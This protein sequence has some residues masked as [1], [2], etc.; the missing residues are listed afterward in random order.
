M[1][2][3]QAESAGQNFQRLFRE[4]SLTGLSDGQLL[5]RYLASRDEFAFEVLVERHAALVLSVCRRSLDDPADCDDA[6]Q[7]T[8]LVLARRGRVVRNQ[9]ALASWLFGVARR[10]CLLANRG[11]A[12]RR[13][14]ERRAAKLRAGRGTS[15]VEPAESGRLVYEEI[16]RLPSS[17]RLPVVLCLMEGRSRSEAAATLCWTES[18]V[19]GRLAR[20]RRLL[21]S[22]LIRRGVAPAA[23]VA[24]LVREGRA[25][26]TVP[27]ALVEGAAHAASG[28]TSAKVIALTEGVIKIML[29]KKLMLSAAVLCGAILV[30]W[31]SA[32]VLSA[33]EEQAPAVAV[34]QAGPDRTAPP[35]FIPLGDPGKS[36][37]HG[38]VIDP[39]GKPVA[40]AQ[41]RMITQGKKVLAESVTDGTGAFRLGPLEPMYRN[42]FELIVDA[43]GLGRVMSLRDAIRSFPGLDG[44]VGNIQLDRGRVFTGQVLDIDG[45]TLP[46]ATIEPSVYRHVMGHTVEDIGPDLT[47]STDA[48]GRFRTPPLPVGRLAL[49]VRAAGR[50]LGRFER[51]IRPGGEEDL[52][53]IRLEKDVPV[54]GVVKDE[55]GRPIDGVT[56]VAGSGRAAT[57]NA[58]GKFTVSGLGPNPLFQMNVRKEGYELLVGRVTVTDAGFRYVTLDIANP[59]GAPRPRPA[60]F[61]KELAVTLK[62]VGWIDGRAV[63]SDT[64]EPVRLEHVALREFVRKPNGEVVLRR[65]VRNEFEQPEPGRFRVAFDAPDEFHLTFSAAGYQDAEAFTPKVTELKTVEGIVARMKKKAEGAAPTIVRQTIAGTVTREGRP[66]KSGWVALWRLMRSTNAINAPVRRGRTVVGPPMVNAA[67]IRDGSYTIDTPFQ[68]EGWYVV[69]EEPGYPLTQVGPITVAQNE[70][71]TLDIACTEGG[72]I[73]GLVK[74]VPAGWERNVWVVAFS[75]TAVREEARVEPDGT[76]ALPPLPP[77]EYGLKA[78]HDAYE[79]AEVY[80]GLLV[81]DHPEAAKEP[82][83]PWKRAKVVTVKAGQETSGVEVEFPSP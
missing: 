1:R 16:E 72:R 68:S 4:G 26:G 34:K 71:K 63:D 6:F 10:A 31:T 24:A 70:K 56:I 74:S 79:D 51:P 53:A 47:L 49:T 14:H 62:R 66:V 64:G 5:E 36:A 45:R 73:R 23:A 44:D 60:P 42:R 18:T 69:V 43:D 81:R 28:R 37:L 46:N 67:A 65:G 59:T 57:T 58:E 41:V 12:R 80:P 55:E 39:D 30:A 48:E 61:T 75:K 50:Q 2:S 25:A 8:F 9:K 54:T 13:K 15:V 33:K 17:Y 38:R 76:F 3:G 11:A 40:G 7:A 27:R 20:A 77:G 22:R 29:L 21:R 32:M 78:G 52:G 19:R 83:D 35:G 82:A